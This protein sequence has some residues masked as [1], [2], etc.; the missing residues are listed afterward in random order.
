MRAAGLDEHSETIVAERHHQRQRSGL[1]QRFAAGEF[2]ERQSLR[3]FDGGEWDR[4][5]AHFGERIGE[6]HLDSLGESV[7][8]IA[9]GAAQIAGREPHEDARQPGESA[10][11]LQTQIDFVDNQRLG[12]EVKLKDVLDC[13]TFKSSFVMEVRKIVSVRGKTDVHRSGVWSVDPHF[14]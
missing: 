4:E 1:E 11:A 8:G 9:V 14:V 6:R 10:L 7:G 3:S 13:S 5:F 12:H 2:N